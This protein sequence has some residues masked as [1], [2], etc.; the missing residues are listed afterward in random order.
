MLVNLLFWI[1]WNVG[2]NNLAPKNCNIS[3]RDPQY[4]SDGF[5]GVALMSKMQLSHPPKTS[6]HSHEYTHILT[7]IVVCSALIL[8]IKLDSDTF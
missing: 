6:A 1:F 4:G 5:S 7:G 2:V 3:G 8:A